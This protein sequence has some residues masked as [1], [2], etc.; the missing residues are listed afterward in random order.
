MIVH[1]ELLRIIKILE[2]KVISVYDVD[3][4]DTLHALNV[5][6]QYAEDD[7]RQQ[8]LLQKNTIKDEQD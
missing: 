1:I 3:L 5:V 4:Y 7:L 2:A 8:E 6:R